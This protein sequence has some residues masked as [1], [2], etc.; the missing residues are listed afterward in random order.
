[1]SQLA[2]DLS[3]FRMPSS[4]TMAR[5]E[6]GWSLRHVHVQPPE[7][8][9]RHRLRPLAYPRSIGGKEPGTCPICGIAIES[10][11]GTAAPAVNPEL[12]D[13]GRRFW[14]T[15]AVTLPLLAVTMGDMLPGAPVPQWLSPRVRVWTEL[16]LATPACLWSAWPFYLRAYASIRNLHLNMSTLIGL[17]VSVV[18]GYSVIAVLAP[19]LFPHDLLRHMGDQVAVYFEADTRSPVEI[20]QRH[21]RGQIAQLLRGCDFGRLPPCPLVLGRA[22]CKSSDTQYDGGAAMK[23][24]TCHE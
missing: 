5:A 4:L 23:A 1:M 2:D 20:R 9:L 24:G 3:N 18:Y 6:A 16:T 15:A 21:E 13:M 19:G 11:N 12:V 17:G 22:A 14:F 10:R 8:V 7:T